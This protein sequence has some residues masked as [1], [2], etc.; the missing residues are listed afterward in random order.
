M[1]FASRSGRDRHSSNSMDQLE[2]FGG[3]GGGPVQCLSS[4]KS[5][6]FGKTPPR[7]PSLPSQAVGTLENQRCTSDDIQGERRHSHPTPPSA[8]SASNATPGTNEQ[9]ASA[10]LRDESGSGKAADLWRSLESMEGCEPPSR[11]WYPFS[12]REVTLLIGTESA[13]GGGERFVFNHPTEWD[14]KN[15]RPKRVRRRSKSEIEQEARRVVDEMLDKQAQGAGSPAEPPTGQTERLHQL[16]NAFSALGFSFE[17][18]LELVSQWQSGDSPRS[19]GSFPLAEGPVLCGPAENDGTLSREVHGASAPAGNSESLNER[20]CPELSENEAFSDSVLKEP[21]CEDHQNRQ[22]SPIA[23]PSGRKPYKRASK[24]LW[25]SKADFLEM[26]WT[27]RATEIGRELNRHPRTVTDK[28][29]ELELPRPDSR[30]WQK[31]KYGEV[32]EIPEHIK[33]LISELRREAQT[34]ADSNGSAPK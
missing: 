11:V 18:A 8:R 34:A 20:E 24:L 10:A 2:L 26:L 7:A 16:E 12:H 15:G 25:P 21:E 31:Q 22:A 3:A 30:H 17:S 28:A 13:G 6:D 1:P 14:E 9:P 23:A 19:N 33:A 27:K 32:M 29:D 4:T 5:C